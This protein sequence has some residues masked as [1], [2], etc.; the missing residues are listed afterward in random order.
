MSRKSRGLLAAV[1]AV[2]ICAGVLFSVRVSALGTPTLFHNDEKWYKDS[3]AHL[4]VIDG[5]PYIPVDI[6]G[7]FPHIELSMDSRK[8]EFMLYNR[9]TER[10]ISVLYEKRIATVDGTE[11][12]YLNLYRLYGGYYYVPAEYFCQVM[13]LSCTLRDSD[14]MGEKTMRIWDGT[15]TK[16]MEELLALYTDHGP[17]SS[18]PSVTEPVTPP[19]TSGVDRTERTVY[20]TFNTVREDNLFLLLETMRDANV[21]ATFFFQEEELLAAPKLVTQ[22]LTDGH[23]VG[24]TSA[25]MTDTADFLRQM[26]EANEVLYAITKMT[27]RI[28]QMPGGSEKAGLTLADYEMLEAAGYVLWD[29]TYDVPDSMGYATYAVRNYTAAA[30]RR[31]EVSVLRMSTNNTV[32]KILPQLLADFQTGGNYNVLPIRASDPEIRQEIPE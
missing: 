29:F 31:A 5:I 6:F 28:V 3:T 14:A 30:V 9:T 7:M 19:D 17:D 18:T 15:Q 13:D 16:T 23:S 1:L 25:E 2:C 11:E 8:G 4:E 22:L 27:T 12:I 20:L 26:E 24:L 32:A 21:Q 10:Y